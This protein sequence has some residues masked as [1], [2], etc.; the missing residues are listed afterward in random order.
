[1][2]STAESFIIVA[3][4]DPNDVQLLKWAFAK[5]GLAALVHFVHDGAEA[6]DYLSGTPPFNDRTKYPFPN[7]MM[8]DLKMPCVNGFELLSWLRKQPSLDRLEVAV[9]SG[10]CWQQDFE[11]ARALGTS[12]FLNKSLDLHEVVAAIKDL[13]SVR[14]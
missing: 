14:N 2:S 4:D 10:S 1:M 3:E 11:R 13:V 8:L 6:M 12:L 9:M 5:A 7:L